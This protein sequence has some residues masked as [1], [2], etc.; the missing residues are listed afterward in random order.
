MTEKKKSNKAIIL[1]C[2]ILIIA[3]SGG[4][5]AEQNILYG[6]DK[7]AFEIMQ[8]GLMEFKDPSSVRVIYAEMTTLEGDVF[9][10]AQVSAANGFGARDEVL[11]C[12]FYEDGVFTT[13]EDLLKTVKQ[14]DLEVNAN[15]ITKAI[16]RKFNF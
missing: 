12:A 2:I 13:D 11:E 16:K 3:I 14:K 6:R 1:F 7:E 8:T 4:I 9:V 5:Y 10:V 15:K